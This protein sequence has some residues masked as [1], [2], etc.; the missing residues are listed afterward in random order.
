ML[1][2][3][4]RY[5][6]F[7]YVLSLVARSVHFKAITTRTVSFCHGFLPRLLF[8]STCVTFMC[9]CIEDVTSE[10]AL[11]LTAFGH[12]GLCRFSRQ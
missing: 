11:S 1:H 3:E 12:K 7:T 10:I 9:H 4:V 8:I 6:D 5:V 2:G